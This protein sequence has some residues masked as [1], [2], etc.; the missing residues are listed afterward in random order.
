MATQVERISN[1]ERVG[2]TRYQVEIDVDSD[3]THATIIRLAGKNKRVLELGCGPGHMSRILRERGCNV[4]AIEIDPIAAERA[5]AC[6]ENV[7]VGDLEDMDF[8]REL[9]GARFDL[10]IAADVLEHLKD[11]AMVLRKIKSHLRPDG[12]F[13]VSIPNVAH[14]SVRLALLSGRFPYAETGLLDRT[15]LR[16]FTRDSVER[17]FDDAGIAIGRFHRTEAVPPNP[18]DFEVPYDPASIPPDLLESL[19]KD[20]E[21]RTY[22][23]VVVGYVLPRAGLELIQERIRLLA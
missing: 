2:A 12:Y 4:T 23:F 13:I 17:L 21:A 6:C 15:H 19:S 16:F 11:P 20:P 3:T 9:G 8:D 1:L 10:I 18:H 5:S 22:Q 7:I 14:L